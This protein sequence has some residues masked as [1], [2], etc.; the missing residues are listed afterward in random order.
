MRKVLYTTVLLAV[1]VTVCAGAADAAEIGKDL[2]AKLEGIHRV[3]ETVRVVLLLK[4]KLPG[5]NMRSPGTRENVIRHLQLQSQRSQRDVINFINILS[6]RGGSDSG[7]RVR[8]FWLSNCLVMEAP[9]SL[10]RT[11][12]E[13]DDVERIVL[14]KTFTAIDPV[15]A[16]SKDLEL[17][18][19]LP[20][21]GVDKVWTQYALDGTGV[22]VGVTD[23]GIN[24]A[25]GYAQ[26]H[27]V[28][29]KGF[30]NGQMTQNFNDGQGHG[31]HVAG[32]ICGGLVD[33][34]LW[35]MMWGMWPTQVGPWKGKIGVA[36]GIDLY[37]AK[38]LSDSGSG[39]FEDIVAGIQWL[40]DPDGDPET[41]DGVDLINSSLGASESVPELREP[42]V[43]AQAT[44]VFL[45]FAAGNSGQVCGSPADFPEIFAVGAI[46]SSA[47]RAGFSSI[48]P[49]VFDDKEWIKPDI[50][51]PGVEVISYMKD[52]L[53]A[54]D[55]T[56]MAC[57]NTAGVI[58][59]L[60]QADPSLT[61]E[62]IKAVLIET[63]IDGGTE[64]PDNYYG[65]GRVDALAAVKK[66]I[67]DK[68][69]G[70]ILSQRLVLLANLEF[71]RLWAEKN[72]DSAKAFRALKH[73]ARLRELIAG[74]IAARDID[75]ETLD[76]TIAEVSTPDT[77]RLFEL[78][79]INVREKAIREKLGSGR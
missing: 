50:M 36:P 58:S 70:L 20:L 43:N 34:T 15:P 44:G 64:G 10:V 65:Y 2:A 42:L 37:V 60:L 16:D 48:G 11:L 32:T 67:G 68:E 7:V 46:N 78:L 45:C 62:Q 6:P 14:E 41:D 55:G 39:T 38:V 25:L 28:E 31:T 1:L 66:V 35:K 75:E 59:L 30:S 47:A 53:F 3:D 69:A 27:L 18:Y 61:V 8:S 56:S 73:Q 19:G 77:Q 74:F 57:P 26:E 72:R 21:M 17:P 22:K 49:V 5:L 63:A 4:D 33:D 54:L 79:K 12:T 51:A 24:M 29:G 13:Y 76:R 9:L 52:R 40:I 23:T 71:D